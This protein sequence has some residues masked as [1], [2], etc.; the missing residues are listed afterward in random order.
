MS[1]IYYPA[2]FLGTGFQGEL[3]AQVTIGEVG[4]LLSAEVIEPSTYKTFDEAAIRR[5]RSLTYPPFPPQVR[6]EE[7]TIRVPIVYRQTRNN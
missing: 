7:V 1:N 4:E 3:V 5:I 6:V 2:E